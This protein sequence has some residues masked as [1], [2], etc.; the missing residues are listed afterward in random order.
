VELLLRT[1]APFDLA[2]ELAFLAARAVPG[3]EAWDGLRYHRALDLEHGHAVAVVSPAVTVDDDGAPAV[4]VELRLEDE[5][6]VD[7]AVVRLRRLF[8]LDADPLVVDRALGADEVLAPLVEASPGRRVPG[9]VDPFETAV[10]AVVGQQ[11]SVAGA[12]TVAGRVVAAVGEPL[13]LDGGPLTHVFP[14]PAR[15]AAAD[16]TVFAMPAARARTIVELATRVVDGRLDLGLG[17]DR[18]DLRGAL[19]DV[20]GIGP[21]TAGY[22]AMR[23]LGDPDVFLPTDLGVKVGLAALGVGADRADRWRP[24]RSYALHH[25]WA[26]SSARWK[27]VS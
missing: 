10:R 8:D 7:D 17:A 27:E 13:R 26:V 1:R 15:L 9:T 18:V 20:P 25:L 24:W 3:V 16:R 19:H 2:G 14:A 12:R 6:D 11:I 5:R 22:V 4:P 23:G 21:W